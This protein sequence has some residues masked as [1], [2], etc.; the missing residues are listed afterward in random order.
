M[1]V[2]VVMV[3]EQYYP[4]SHDIVGVYTTIEKALAS[5]KSYCED[6]GWDINDS[7]SYLS[8]DRGEYAAILEQTLDE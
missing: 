6:L 1:T 2:Y 4:S 8:S 3:G 7:P 5:R